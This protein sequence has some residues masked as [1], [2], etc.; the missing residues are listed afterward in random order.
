M[1][2]KLVLTVCFCSIN[3]I[4]A[5][6]Q[7]TM[8]DEQVLEYVTTSVASGKSMQ[9]IA[10]ELASK[11]VTRAQAERVR[12]IYQKGGIGNKAEY[13]PTK[14]NASRAH[15]TVEDE[16]SAEEM[17]SQNSIIDV[18]D[19]RTVASST[20]I[21]GYNIFKNKTLNFAPSENL[22]TPRNYRLGPGDEVII[23]VYGANQT[24]LRETISP[25]GSINVDILGPVYLN[26]MTINDANTFL[27]K[28][29]STIF[30]GLGRT[31]D[32]TDIRVSLGQIRTIQINVLGEVE[33]PGTYSL[34]S[35]STVFHALY[36]AGGVKEPGTLRNIKVSRGGRTIGTVDIY[37]F[38]MH[39]TRSSDIRLEE[40]DVILVA[41]YKTMV[42]VEGKVKRPMFFEMKDGESLKTLIEYAG[43]YAKGAYTNN[44]TIVRQT[45]RE[46]EVCNVDEMDYSVFKMKD[47]DE[48]QVGELVSKFQNRISVKGA[49]FRT[50][51]FQLDGETNT[52]RS[53][54]KKADGLLPEAF[55]SHA[56]LSRE[57]DDRSLEVLSVDIDAIMN[58]SAPDIP[59]KN[60]DELYVPSQFD[61][62]DYGNVTIEGQVASPAVYPFAKNMTIEDLIL[63]AGGLLDAASTCRI[64]VSR[65]IKDSKARKAS[66]KIGELFSF[67]IDENLSI[68]SG[69]RNFTLQP[70][71]VVYVRKSPSYFV[72]RNVRVSGEIN[73]EGD[74][75]LTSKNERLSELVNKAGGATDFAYLKGARLIR[76]VNAVELAR[77]KKIQQGL[78][79]DTVDADILN[80][81]TRYYVGIELD[82]ALEKPGSEYDVVLREGDELLIP[83]Y[84]S[85]VRVD[86]AVQSPVDVTFANNKRVKYYINQ[87][88]GYAN[89]AKKSRM[90]MVS[91]NGH[92]SR[93]KKRTRVDPGAEII[94]PLK[95]PKD[96]SNIQT[97]L[98][99]ATTSTSLA[100]MIASI[101]NILK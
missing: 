18:E 74:Y 49:V 67:S 73:F 48:V 30:A 29:L 3:I 79:T 6:A 88:G 55:T 37:E 8:T 89:R 87:A 63:Q 19:M 13:I 38:L 81:D 83:E 1:L 84:A 90:Y 58:G 5:F 62:K 45:G 76:K 78:G 75:P 41:P 59:L 33:Y 14:D 93:V 20:E 94:V 7:S 77:M 80:S 23:D 35:F 53:L 66:D 69:D 40:G 85:T 98:S 21:F 43:G 42:K 95:A 16:V 97:T 72:A 32:R 26:G 101:A 2:K 50:G 54:I 57:N 71:D 10:V 31:N 34:S 28:K 60:N 11:G 12:K 24:T 91:M 56:I 47:G 51:L 99:L 52:I 96:G 86:G 9:T 46:Y 17:D 65:R 25:E 36:R 15:N 27:K 44:I 92:V 4:V 61:I 68:V 64:D 100:T 70:Y 82:M 22:A 39:G